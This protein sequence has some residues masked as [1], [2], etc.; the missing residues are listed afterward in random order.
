[1]TSYVVRYFRQ[2]FLKL[3]ITKVRAMV[4]FFQEHRKCTLSSSVNEGSNPCQEDLGDR[5]PCS[6]RS[7]PSIFSC[8]NFEV[9]IILLNIYQLLHFLLFVNLLSL[10]LVIKILWFT[11]GQSGIPTPLHFP[12]QAFKVSSMNILK[13]V[14]ERRHSCLSPFVTLNLF[15]TL[16]L[17]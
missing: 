8:F 11:H 13:Q 4:S 16:L 17:P 5:L 3:F 1:M 9:F 14:S 6:I 7:H 10:H 15:D 2:W 12:S